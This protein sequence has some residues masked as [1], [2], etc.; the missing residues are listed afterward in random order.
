M[1]FIIIYKA[2]VINYISIFLHLY[3]KNSVIRK[4]YNLSQIIMIVNIIRY[5]VSNAYFVIIT[6]QAEFCYRLHSERASIIA[7]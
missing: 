3:I 4:I 7:I 1:T 2:E 6:F 5:T